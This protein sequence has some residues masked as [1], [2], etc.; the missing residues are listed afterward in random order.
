MEMKRKLQLDLKKDLELLIK[1]PITDAEA[2]QAYFN[3]SGFFK[4]LNQMKKEAVVYGK[5]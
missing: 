2:W 5:V 4:V 1:Q 3:L